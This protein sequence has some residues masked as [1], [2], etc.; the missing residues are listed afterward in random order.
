M[1]LWHICFIEYASRMK[2]EFIPSTATD[3]R[4]MDARKDLAA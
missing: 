4:D 3:M 2:L 1:Q